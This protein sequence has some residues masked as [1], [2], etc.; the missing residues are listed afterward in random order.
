[1][2]LVSACLLGARCRYDGKS[3]RDEKVLKLARKEGL[4]PICPEQLGGLPTPREPAWISRGDGWDVLRGKA[5]VIDR[6]G[7]DVTE[8]F[9]RGAKEALRIARLYGVREAILKAKSP[10]CGSGKIYE[11]YSDKVKSGDG[12]TTALLKRNG[13][14]VLTEEEL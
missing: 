2:K 9:R 8:N 5:K 12:V 11:F 7:V 4:I 13:I 10:S 3:C 6:M 14:S 1:M